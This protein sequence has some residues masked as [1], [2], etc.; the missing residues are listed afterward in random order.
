MLA[1]AGNAES[2]FQE[3]LPSVGALIL[4]LTVFVL[5]VRHY[6]RRPRRREEAETPV[7]T[8]TQ[9]EELRE[10]G[11]LSDAE[12]ILLRTQA[13]ADATGRGLWSLQDV[14]ELH[15]AGELTDDEFQLAKARVIAAHWPA[16]ESRTQGGQTPRAEGGPDQTT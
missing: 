6:R 9:L 16:R 10:R 5:V 14:R 15:A 12:H 1:R 3:L 4:A 11:E 2:L 13:I 8:F 7:W